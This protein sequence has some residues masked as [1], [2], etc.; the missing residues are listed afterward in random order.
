M[1]TDNLQG[2]ALPTLS[3]M[4]VFVMTFGYFGTQVAFSMQTGSMGRIF[5]TIGAN[6]ENLGFFFILPP[7]A[8][9][10]TQPL[11]GYF[12][13]KT[14][15][16]RFGRRMP[17]LIGGATVSCLVMVLLPNAGYF[18]RQFGHLAALLFAALIVLIMDLAANVSQQPF[19]MIIPDMANARQ[20]NTLWTMQ[21]VWGNL[22]SLIAFAC[23][24]FLTALGLANTAAR[25]EVPLSVKVAFYLAAAVLAIATLF[26]VRKVK[27]YPPD[28]MAQY[29]PAAKP[30]GQRASL[31]QVIKTAPK[32]FWTLGLVEFFVWLAVPYLWTFS[33]G[34]LAEKIWHCTDPAA[35]DFQA[36]GNWFGLVQALYAAVAILVGLAF[37]KLTRRTR[38]PAFTLSLLLG[39][40]GFYLLATGTSKLTSLLAFT[41]L[42]VA[43]IAVIS[44]PFTI[45]TNA[46]TGAHDG[47]MLGLFNC[48]ICL[49]QMLSSALAFLLLPAMGHSMAAMFYLAAGS[50]LLA[51]GSIWLVKDPL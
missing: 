32:V 42:G 35:A 39:A 14:W 24:F 1:R 17:Y 46:L 19:K 25:G 44:I 2:Q 34:A 23:P 51:A 11:I 20:T 26:T 37:T 21:N 40:L 29:H 5:Q 7:L 48:F 30:R 4:Q 16:P 33:T 22:G 8:G 12:S 18:G 9:M 41:L 27:E 38:R 15:S 3:R 36:A 43:W 50:F 13:D 49:P 10:V 6:P 45:L 31:G 28:L 47:I